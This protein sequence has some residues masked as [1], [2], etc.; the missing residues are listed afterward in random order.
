TRVIFQVPSGIL[1]GPPGF[2]LT[3]EIVSVQ[4]FRDGVASNTVGAS[5]ASSSPAIF[6]V[7]VNGTNYPGRFVPDG[8]IIGESG[9]GAEM[10]AAKPGDSLQLS[11]T[12]LIRTT[13]GVIPSAQRYGGVTVK[14]GDIAFA[15]DSATLAVP[16]VFQINFRVPQQFATLPEGDYPIT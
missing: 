13:S 3:S 9:S 15:A 6:V 14:L 7:T 2:I 10:R 12:G 5:A 4:L 16:G 11:A 8:Q 1:S